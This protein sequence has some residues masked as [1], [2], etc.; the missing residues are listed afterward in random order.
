MYKFCLLSLVLIV[1]NF[2]QL[3]A[4]KQQLWYNKPA[5]QW[6]EALP[7]GNGRLGAMVFGGVKEELLQLNEATLWSGGPVKENVNPNAYS[8]LAQVRE[9]LFKEDYE[10]AR[11]LT[12]KMQGVYSESFLPLGDLKIK[13]KFE[14]EQV[15][16]YK[17]DLDIQR[18]IA[19]TSFT[20][21]GVSY[22]REVFSSAPD[23]VIVMKISASKPK[24]LNL[25]IST[26][27]Q[28]IFTKSVLPGHVLSLGGR[29]PIHADPVYVKN[30][31]DPIRYGTGKDCAGMPYELLAKAISND[32]KIVL[33]TAGITVSNATEV[34]IYL[35]A[36]TGFNGFNNCP[37]LDAQKLAKDKLNLASTKTWDALLIAHL[38]DFQKYFNRVSFKLNADE[39]SKTNMPT[40]ERLEAYTKGES[41]SE[42]E[43]LY[44][45]YGRYLLISSSRVVGV[46]ANLQ[47]I[48]NKEMRPPWS[49]NYTTNINVQMNYWMAENCNLSEMHTPLF[50]LIKNL[51]VTG[52]EVSSSF[53][54]TRGWVTHHNSDIW[55]LANPVGDLGSGDPKWANWPMGGDWLT[56]HL[57]EHYQ[58]TQDKAFLASTAY[59][60]MKGA[61]EFTLDWLVPDKEGYLVTAPSFSPENDFIYGNKKVGQVSVA[62]TMD[63][64]IIRD[65]FDNLI[66]AS[67]I[68]NIDKAFRDTLIAKK[69][70]LLPYQIGSKGQLQEWNKD[71]E[72][73][74]PHHRHVS[75]L[76][77]LYPANQISPL[78][79]PKFAEA[80]KK[81]LELRGDDG[82]GWSLA[83]KVNMWARL[84]DG[85][86]AYKLYRNLFRITRENGTN[87]G[88]GGGIYPNMFDAHPPFQIDGNFGGT[89]GVAEM[90][91]QSQDGY[92]HLLP[93]LPKVWK[94]GKITGLMSRGAFTV[95]IKWV[96]GKLK[97]ATVTPKK[98]GLCKILSAQ[99]LKINAMVNAKNIK[100]MNGYMLEFKATAGRVYT[101]SAM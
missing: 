33:D 47:G 55:A 35:S 61:A 58:Y 62:T 52:S 43:A 46:P 71:Y 38:K 12:Q 28:I 60:L 31:K 8:H 3:F 98:A 44:F 51:S 11:K 6:T 56:R 94:E 101:L 59:P 65:L 77:A 27:S 83:W 84:L 22:K 39:K 74:D 76:F 63:M 68:L 82:T 5:K 89:S 19:T 95:D 4:Q 96:A 13:Q 10:S 79:T 97:T 69:A 34:L 66:D 26:S 81:T 70:K 90:L 80:A 29:A 75:H 14:N 18:A 36:A 24:M 54:K 7:V 67:K 73:P 25:C 49:S 91:M 93:A 85:D 64:G 42:L 88:G 40:D 92:I 99:K 100:T 37:N 72:S 9:A 78:T 2:N 50:G 86:H 15:S 87:Y 30:T 53:Y 41:D 21:N 32:G 20:V 1:L 23:Q 45:Q 17:R 57:W 16:A 48:W